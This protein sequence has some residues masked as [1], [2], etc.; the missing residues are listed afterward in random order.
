[1]V[2]GEVNLELHLPGG[3]PRLGVLL[4]L[5]PDCPGVEEL[6]VQS[7]QLSSWSPMGIPDPAPSYHLVV[8]QDHLDDDRVQGHPLDVPVPLPALVVAPPRGRGHLGQA[9]RAHHPL[10]LCSETVAISRV[11]L[12][13]SQRSP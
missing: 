6:L 9:A 4:P 11:D 7:Y 5:G 1:M 8:S 10:R 12:F 13:F 2:T 3:S